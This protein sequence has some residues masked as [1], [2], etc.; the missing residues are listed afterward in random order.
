M[1][2]TSYFQDE[3]PLTCGDDDPANVG[4]GD[5]ANLG[6]I[7]LR[8]RDGRGGIDLER[9]RQEQNQAR[10]EAVQWLMHNLVQLWQRR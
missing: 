1:L 2:V 10:R 3:R 7:P 8:Y 6:S 9:V 4:R 5:D